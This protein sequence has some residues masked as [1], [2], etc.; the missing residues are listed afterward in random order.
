MRLITFTK[1]Q[2][3]EMPRP[4]PQYY[5]EM[6][7]IAHSE[8]ENSLI[9][10][11]D[12]HRYLAMKQKYRP[13]GLGDTIADVLHATKVDKVVQALASPCGCLE[14]QKM[15]NELIPYGNPS[16]NQS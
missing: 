9:F 3:R 5:E 14:R 16:P 7:S 15:L 6:L 11:R 10:D 12:D 4:Q 1:Q 13:Q 2:L 8:E